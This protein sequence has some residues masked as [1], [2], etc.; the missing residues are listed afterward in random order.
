MR[1]CR[2]RSSRRPTQCERRAG[3]RPCQ[4]SRTITPRQLQHASGKG[5]RGRTAAAA[6]GHAL[7]VVE[8]AALVL[9]AGLALAPLGAAVRAPSSLGLALVGRDLVRRGRGPLERR[10]RTLGRVVVD[11][12][13]GGGGGRRRLGPGQD[14]PASV[15]GGG[16]GE[17]SPSA[18]V[19]GSSQGLETSRARN[20]LLLDVGKALPLGVGSGHDGVRLEGRTG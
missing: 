4:R 2:R 1:T 5:E 12:G 3:R 20:A 6:A 19:P 10:A 8:L 14:V 15:V 9:P 18:R 11:G 7:D 16:R 13:R 17:L